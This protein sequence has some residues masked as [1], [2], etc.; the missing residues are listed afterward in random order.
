MRKIPAELC[1]R[2]KG[3]KFLCGLP[4]C[5]ITQ[6]FRSI[7]NTTSKIS[8]EKGIIEGSTPPSAIVGERGYPKVSLNFNVVP[9]VTGEETRIYND[10]A[11]WWGKANIYDIINYRSSLVSNLSEVRIT[12]VWKLYEKE[13]S[14]AI[15]SEKPVVSESKI[16]GKLETKLRFD[17]VVMPRGPSVVAENIRIVEDPKPPRTLEKLFNDDLKAEEG[18][19]VLYEEG[20]D[21]YRII[22]AL[23]LGFL[24]KRKTRKLVPTRW[25]ITAVD[26]I[27]GKS[28]YEKV[29]DLEP[30]NEISVFYQGYL[31]NHFHV[32]LFPSAYAS[33]W[34][35]IWHQMSLWANEL[36]ISDLKE[37]YWGNYETIDGGYMAARTSVLEYLNSIRR[38]AGVII[39]REITRDYFAPLGNWHIRETVRRSF[40]NKIAVVENLQRAI[41]LVNSRLKVQGVNLREVRVIKQVLGQSRIDS[42]FS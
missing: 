39:V 12:D 42:F 27:V 26:S 7:V 18:V 20:N 13:L 19:R 16:T 22:D 38:S 1:V 34:V 33:Y 23:S 30:V 28:L 5:P 32:I 24:G 15:V 29:R 40:Q 10:P 14:L 31:G 21:V 35:E 36:V 41:D 37:D 25:A 8:L 3:T 17:G 9:G 11:N 2:C 4:S 6:R